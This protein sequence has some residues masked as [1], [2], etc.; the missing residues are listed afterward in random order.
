MKLLLLTIYSNYDQY[1]LT[2]IP[3]LHRE[4]WSLDRSHHRENG[5]AITT[6]YKVNRW[7]INGEN[8]TEDDYK[9]HYNGV[10]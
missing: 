10:K 2:Y 9:K 5:P 4:F 7:W 6:A 3:Y 8:Y 1:V